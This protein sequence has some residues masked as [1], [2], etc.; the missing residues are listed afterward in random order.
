MDIVGIVDLLLLAGVV[1]GFFKAKFQNI[2]L[3]LTCYNHYL[4]LYK[5]LALFW[6]LSHFANSRK[7]V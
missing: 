4:A 5:I 7:N 6:M 2:G 1:I 3:I